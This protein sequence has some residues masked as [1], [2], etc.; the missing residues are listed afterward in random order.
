MTTLSWFDRS[1][2]ILLGVTAIGA[3]LLMWRI[4]YLLEDMRHDQ[5]QMINIE[6]S[7]RVLFERVLHD[8]Q[9]PSKVAVLAG[10]D[11]GSRDDGFGLPTPDPA[12]PAAS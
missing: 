12:E 5:Q 2:L 7:K 1:L 3:Y 8:E 10:V 4:I 11:S 6:L 9:K